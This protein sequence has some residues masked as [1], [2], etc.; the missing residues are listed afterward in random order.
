MNPR[1]NLYISRR[2]HLIAPTHRLLDAASEQAKGKAKIGSTLKGIGPTYM[3]KTGRNGLRVGDLTSGKF[4]E[5]YQALR[6]KHLAPR[7]YPISNTT[8]RAWK[9]NGS[10]PQRIGPTQLIDTEHFLNE[11][12]DAGK[13]V[14]AEG[15][16]GT[17]LDIDFGTYP[18]VTSSNTIAAGACNGLGVGPGRIGEVIGIFKAYCTRGQRSFPTELLD[19]TG[20][21]LR[22]AGG[23]Y[24]ATTGRP[25]RCGGSTRSTA[26]CLPRQR[27]HSTRHDEGR[28]LSGFDAIPVCHAYEHAGATTANLPFGIEPDEVTPTYSDHKGWQEDLT[29][30]TTVEGLP[31]SLHDYIA[32]VEDEMKI[33]V[34]VVSVGPDRAQ[35]IQR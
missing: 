16:Q 11:A 17:M 5:R 7:P 10:P 2:A 22:E 4:E 6:T 15:A 31:A 30:V 23:E 29:S 13:R 27:R 8:S 26:L 28:C 1:P 18:F 21:A 35:T 12:L 33:P 20:E 19:E 24:G 25:R 32:M 9:Q 34:K 14:L 3:D